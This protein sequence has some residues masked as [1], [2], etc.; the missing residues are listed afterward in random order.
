MFSLRH[1]ILIKFEGTWKFRHQYRFRSWIMRNYY[2]HLRDGCLIWSSDLQGPMWWWPDKLQKKTLASSGTSLR[3]C[4]LCGEDVWI[5]GQYKCHMGL[6][7]GGVWM[8][9]W[10]G[11]SSSGIGCGDDGWD[12]SVCCSLTILWNCNWCGWHVD[13][14]CVGHWHELAAPLACLQSS[15]PWWSG[16]L[17]DT[18]KLSQRW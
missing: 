18:S 12:W 3:G 17:M 2:T 8:M 16:V 10:C 9:M 14:V 4:D 5:S 13:V 11:A 15:A 7:C 1:W 6:R